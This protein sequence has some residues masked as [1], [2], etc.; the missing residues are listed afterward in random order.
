MVDAYE[1][2]L[3]RE[4]KEDCSGHDPSRIENTIEQVDTAKR[5]SQM[6]RLVQA[7]LEKTE[8][9]DRVKGAAG[10]VMQG[11]LSVKDAI[12]SGLQAVPQAAIAWTSICF[13]LQMF[14]NPTTESKLNRDGTVHV[15]A[16]M[17]W[18]C[19]LSSILLKKDTDNNVSFAGI[20]AELEKRVID[21][22]RELLFYLVRSVYSCYRNRGVAF[23]RD[24]IKLD[25]W[26]GNLKRVEDAESAVRQDSDVYN[27]HEIKSNLEKLVDIAKKQEKTILQDKKD[28]K[29]FQHLCLTDPRLDKIR[30]ED[31]QGGLLQD[32]YCWILE[33]AD[34][35]RWRED[36]Q[37]RLLWIKGDP[38]KGKTMLLC[39]IIDELK[40]PAAHTYLL[41]FF[42]CQ[43]T[44]SRINSA[45]AVLRGLIYLLV[46][47]QPSLISHVRRKYDHAGRTLFE[48][49]NAW[50]ALSEIFTDILQDPN[51]KGTYLIIDALDECVTDLPK[52]LDFIIQKSSVSSSIKWI[53]SSRNWPEIEEV[54]E[55][56]GQK[57]RMCLELNAESIST[58][59][60]SYIEHKVIHLAQRKK[61][62][63][64]LKNA[65]RDY[66]SSN[67]N[68]TFLWA[69]LV[70]Q[71][72][73]NFWSWEVLAVLGTFPP[74]LDKLYNGMMQR[75]CT[76]NSSN[77]FKQILA[78]VTVVRRPITLKELTSFIKTLE[79]ITD[80]L[81]SLRKIIELCGSFLTLQGDTVYFVHQSAKDFM[82][83]KASTQ[84][85]PSGEAEVHHAIFLRSLEV[86]SRTLHR[87][88]YSLCTPGF[89]ID[90]VQPRDPDPL[91]AVRYS[92][93]F[94]V[95]H[96]KEWDPSNTAKD[97][98]DLGNGGAV[99]KFLRQK[100]LY[101][102]EALSLLG[103]MSEGVL[104]IIMLESILQGKPDASQLTNLVRD[105]RRFILYHKWAIE[106]NPLQVYA[107]ALI[108][109]PS[110]SVVREIFKQEEPSWIK[111]I[112]GMESDWNACLQTLEGHSD[113]VN[114]VVFSH[115]SKHLASASDDKTLKIW[116]ASNGKCLQTLEGHSHLVNSVVFSHD[117]KH[118][119][120]A[121]DDKTLKI[122][123][124][125][126]GKCLQTL[127]GHSH[128][129]N[130][131]VFS[132]DSKHLASASHDKTLKI[133]D[134]SNGKCLQTLEGHSDWVNSVVFSHDSKHL[135]SASHDKTLKIWDAS[136]GKCL[137]TLEGHSHLVNSVV[138]S[139]DSKHLASASRDKTLK[140]WD[141]SNGK[142]LQTL[143][144]H[145][146][147]VN[148]VVFSHDSKHLVSASDDKTLKIWDASNGKC[149]Q[150]LE[151]H[152]DW[153]SSVV[154]SHDSK[155][156]AS[157]S[158][159]ETLKI[160]DASNG[161]CLQTLE[162]HSHLVNSVVFSHDSKHLASASDDKTLKIWDASNGK[163]LQTL[164]G[165]S[166][167]VN[168]VVFSHDSKHLASA[169][170]D[171]T[172]KIWDASNGKCLQTLE[173]HS[174]LVNSVVFSH[175]S[176]HLASASGDETLK[177]WDVSNGK[178][179]Q[180]LES[181]HPNFP[182]HHI[183]RTWLITAA[184][185]PIGLFVARAAL[186]H[187]D[188]VIAG[189]KNGEMDAD[190][191]RGEDFREFYTQ[192]CVREG[193]EG[194]D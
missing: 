40:K 141:A 120:S 129:V 166:H 123:D 152:S 191:E 150:T 103:G 193:V 179:L 35:R 51:L 36:Q 154:F 102:L 68:D 62:D 167:L 159:D 50:V 95:E 5:W 9:E 93:V 182:I 3:S 34:F 119:A 54:L 107:S 137:Q 78:L 186:A 48:D 84:I 38:G 101:W 77:L 85:F 174:H 132:H 161:K 99:D 75:I 26:D 12:S 171:K 33:D 14:V 71:N 67:A 122:W 185:S 115:D 113:L 19:E 74:T 59:V 172:L 55:T 92:C 45:A 194:E 65:V 44:D 15:I 183:P 94:W 165:H 82:L 69:A 127:E 96:L 2:I 66:L 79:G 11:I 58:A 10:E 106:N 169:S 131:V 13:A 111:T 104:S 17:E 20:Q 64:K 56:A 133:W 6:E 108:F 190:D 143:E 153:V 181:P 151:G 144:G 155:H 118:L 89:S 80:D 124:A 23:L 21:L 121:S 178:C 98:N 149:L 147:W 43:A 81:E 163:C 91:A 28:E 160:W 60:R 126:N 46:D 88:M 189:V 22:Y 1:R 18:Y 130:S 73:E 7:R 187:G 184:T 110:N 87:D 39:G 125:S 136:N 32:S 114:S 157:A 52:I 135:V 47:Q 164:E 97:R 61:Y 30:I 76:A 41:S 192:K 70:C 128:L 24:M 138:F 109:S 86:M 156:L 72:L 188:S 162:G 100:Y 83:Q 170:H 4:L 112:P 148:S 134:A 146:D 158:W 175:D 116:D 16:R 8:R 139:H 49:T 27:T 142:C 168:S 90:Q 105:V 25:D 173:G 145:S 53:V 42:F 63:D 57:I 117:S 176:K 180:T 140:I 31:T 37:S 29:C 177:I